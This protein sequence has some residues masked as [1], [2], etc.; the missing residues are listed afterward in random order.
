MKFLL[1]GGNNNGMLE[2]A[3]TQAKITHDVL[4]LPAIYISTVKPADETEEEQ[5]VRCCQLAAESGL[6]V[7]DCRRDILSILPE[8]TADSVCVIDSVTALLRNEMG[9]PDDLDLLAT[10]R[11]IQDLEEFARH[12]RSVVYIGHYVFSGTGRSG[13]RGDYSPEIYHREYFRKG[14]AEVE[15]SLAR[16]CDHVEEMSYCRRYRFK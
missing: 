11:V 1:V 5:C 15:K 10:G 3:L 7:L 16:Y 4:G 2:R 12:V 9:T 6:S 14:L 13:S 8:T